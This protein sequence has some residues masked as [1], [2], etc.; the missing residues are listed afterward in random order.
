MFMVIVDFILWW[1]TRGWL[2]RLTSLF[3]QLK[4]WGSYF[5]LPT[6][7]STMFSPWHQ[8]VT[9]KTP[10]RPLNKIF[11]DI[12]DNGV[13]RFVGFWVRLLVIVAG[14]VLLVIISLVNLAYFVLWPLLPILPLLIYLGLG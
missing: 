14:L 4:K 1:Y 10:D 11:A 13:S 9:P 3:S 12:L 8:I 5:S 7:L 2:L 6:L